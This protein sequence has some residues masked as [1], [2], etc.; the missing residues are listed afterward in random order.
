MASSDNMLH[1]VLTKVG[2]PKPMYWQVSRPV[3]VFDAQRIRI[4]LSAL[5]RKAR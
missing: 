1:V 3:A 2:P 5:L 4:T